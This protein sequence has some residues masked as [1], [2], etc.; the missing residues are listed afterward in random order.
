[1]FKARPIR[2]RFHREM[3]ILVNS[4]EKFPTQNMNLRREEVLLVRKKKTHTLT[5]FV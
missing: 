1:M 2:E 4:N 3:R 5:Q